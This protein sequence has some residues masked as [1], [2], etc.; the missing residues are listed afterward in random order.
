VT[1]VPLVGLVLLSQFKLR[2]VPDLILNLV[3]MVVVE[4]VF[5]PF[6]VAASLV[7]ERT[8]QS[9]AGAPRKGLWLLYVTT[10][11]VALRSRIPKQP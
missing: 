6:P 9:V 10:D 3:G 11:K 5:L 8:E 2:R 7:G 1:T 4:V